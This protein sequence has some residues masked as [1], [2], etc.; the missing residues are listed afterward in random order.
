MEEEL[1]EQETRESLDYI[2]RLIKIFESEII[3]PVLIQVVR[4]LNVENN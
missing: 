2:N 3:L 4:K 1:V